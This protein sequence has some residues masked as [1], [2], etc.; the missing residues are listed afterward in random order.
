MLLGPADGVLA[1]DLAAQLVAL[2]IAL[3]HDYLVAAQ[4]L[5]Q[6]QLVGAAVDVQV[7]VTGVAEGAQAEAV[8]RRSLTAV[9]EEGGNAV[10]GHDDV[11]L[12]EQLIA[13]LY[14]GQKRAA[15]GPDLFGLSALGDHEHVVGP[16]VLGHFGQFL[17]LALQLILAVAH[18]GDEDVGADVLVSGLGRE[19]L[20]AGVGRG[21]VYYV[22][23]HELYGLRAEVGQFYLG[24]AGYGRSNVAEGQDEAALQRGLRYQLERELGYDAEGTLGAYH[25]VQQ[26]VAGAGLAYLAAEFNRFA[27]RQHDRHRQHVV[28][29]DA[30]FHRAH[31]SGVGADVAAHGRG[32]LARVRRVHKPVFQRVRSQVAQQHAR[33]Y[34]HAQVFHVVFEDVVH[35]LR[36]YD[37]T[38]VNRYTAADKAGACAAD[39]DGYLVLIAQLHDSGHLFGALH[40]ADRVGRGLAIDGHFIVRV[41]LAHS[42]AGLKALSADYAAQFIQQRICQFSVIG[43]CFSSHANKLARFALSH[44]AHGP[45]HES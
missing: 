45:P 10:H 26:A 40:A 19:D 16:A 28:A 18:Q 37:H 12:V 17:H 22:A 20:R 29:R 30:V 6:L 21:G 34:A 13:G 7:A 35:L 3:G 43:H 14:G 24:H 4:E 8:S 25:Q 9:G 39:R 42:V 32:L 31:A 5:V 2:G 44:D 1:G 15:G 11:H 41:S 33:L 27:V 38:A 36:A 23:L